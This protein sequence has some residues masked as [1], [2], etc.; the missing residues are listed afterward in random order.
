[1]LVKQNDYVFAGS[2]TG[3]IDYYNEKIF[4]NNTWIIITNWM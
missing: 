3:E 2:I 1:M 4:S